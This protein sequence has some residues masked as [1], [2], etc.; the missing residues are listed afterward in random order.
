[1]IYARRFENWW[2]FETRFENIILIIIRDS[3]WTEYAL[4]RCH[5]LYIM[6]QCMI[7]SN[8]HNVS[9]TNIKKHI[10]A[11]LLCAYLSKPIMKN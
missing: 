6:C 8:L 11:I 7:M 5:I 2:R 3:N 9:K 1:M 10:I 4:V